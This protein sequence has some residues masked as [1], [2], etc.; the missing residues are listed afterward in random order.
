MVPALLGVNQ[1]KNK[2]KGSQPVFTLGLSADGPGACSDAFGVPEELADPSRGDPLIAHVKPSS[3]TRLAKRLAVRMI[4][5][6]DI[7]G[8]GCGEVS[9]EKRDDRSDPKSK[10]AGPEQPA[11]P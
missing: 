8:A 4:A 11:S 10:A 5:G 7:G 3:G 9:E 1:N 6:T 2:E